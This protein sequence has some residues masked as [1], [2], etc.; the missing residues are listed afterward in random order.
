MTTAAPVLLT[1]AGILTGVYLA[2]DWVFGKAASWW[3]RRG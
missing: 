1:I 3:Q 2:A